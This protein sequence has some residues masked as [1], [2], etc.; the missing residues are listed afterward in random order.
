MQSARCV[1][2]LSGD[3]GTK[4]AKAPVSPAEVVLLRAIHG[5]ESVQSVELLNGGVN[6]KTPHAEELQRLRSHYTALTEAGNPVI[7]AVFPG[8]YPQLPTTFDEIGIA[9]GIN[10]GGEPRSAK[11]KKAAAKNKAAAAAAAE[12]IAGDEAG[13]DEASED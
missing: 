12:E 10:E 9:V 13:A 1:V 2:Q 4:I 3:A 11:G 6:D 8:A 5:P 7:D